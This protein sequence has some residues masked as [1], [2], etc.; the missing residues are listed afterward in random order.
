MKDASASLW[1]K[2]I[3]L[4]QSPVFSVVRGRAL[5]YRVKAGM[6]TPCLTRMLNWKAMVKREEEG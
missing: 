6:M 3:Y 4:G 1:A 2:I 5:A